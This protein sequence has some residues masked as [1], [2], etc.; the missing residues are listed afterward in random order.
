MN[1]TVYWK[2]KDRTLIKRIQ[3]ELNLPNYTTVNGETPCVI[4]DEHL[5]KLQEYEVEGII[6]LRNK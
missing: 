6:Q 3:E 5:P 4:K 2:T 1:T